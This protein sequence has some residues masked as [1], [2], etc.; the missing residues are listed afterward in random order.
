MDE[1]TIS[2]KL[3]EDA[4]EFAEFYAELGSMDRDTLLTRIL[5]ERLKEVREQTGNVSYNDLMSRFDLT[6][7]AARYVLNRLVST[8]LLKNIGSRRV[9]RYVP[10]IENVSVIESIIKEN[11]SV[12]KESTQILDNPTN[13]EEVVAV[14]EILVKRNPEYIKNSDVQAML[15]ERFHYTMC[16]IK[17][18]SQTVVYLQS[19]VSNILSQLVNDGWAMREGKGSKTRYKIMIGCETENAG[20]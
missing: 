10:V 1:E 7:T 14:K 18:A 15:K 5:S 8:G 19:R 20:G 6:K 4:L 11:V 13:K 17:T 12:I 2:L 3:P 9:P 16:D